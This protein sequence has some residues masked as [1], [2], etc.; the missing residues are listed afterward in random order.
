MLHV[1]RGNA[2]RGTEEAIIAGGAHES[3]IS[4]VSRLYLADGSH[5]RDEMD[6]VAVLTGLG[7]PVWLDRRDAHLMK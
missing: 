6:G 1:A 2:P 4:A 5:E 7:R 3:R